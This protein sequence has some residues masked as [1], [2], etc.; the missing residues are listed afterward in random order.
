MDIREF[1]AYDLNGNI[2]GVKRV[3]CAHRYYGQVKYNPD[4]SY[5][6]GCEQLAGRTVTVKDANKNNFYYEI[7]CHCKEMG[8]GKY[9]GH[10]YLCAHYNLEVLCPHLKGEYSPNNTAAL[11]QVLPSSNTK[12][13]WICRAHENKSDCG[14]THYFVMTPNKRTARGVNCSICNGTHGQFCI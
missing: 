11:N 3:I 9:I 2:N 10:G 6:C 1:Y 14:E 4:G 13:K 12:R 8:Y 5:T 7:I